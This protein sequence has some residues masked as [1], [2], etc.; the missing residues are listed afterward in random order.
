MWD[1]DFTFED[2]GYDGNGVVHTLHCMNCGAEIECRVKDDA[3][4]NE[5]GTGE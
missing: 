5:Q 2:F 4:C 1:R 3:A